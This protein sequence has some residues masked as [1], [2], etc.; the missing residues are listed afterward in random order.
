MCVLFFVCFT[1]YFARV[2][3]C[4]HGIVHFVRVV[5]TTLCYMFCACFI[6]YTLVCTLCVLFCL[7]TLLCISCMLFC[8]LHFYMYFVHVV[9]CLF[10]C[11]FCA[12][13][14]FCVTLY[15]CVL[16]QPWYNPFWLSR[17]KTPANKLSNYITD[18]AFCACCFV[19]NT[20]ATVYFVHVVLCIT[21]RLLCILCMSLCV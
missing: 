5:L 8:V 9:L 16:C 21:P 4:V 1:V 2:L 19:Y 7:N 14:F 6:L 10:Y 20:T 12:C 17:M 13:F 18:R 15:C 11:V 3:Y